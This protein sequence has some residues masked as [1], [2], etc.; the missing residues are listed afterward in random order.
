MK[1]YVTF[2]IAALLFA[3]SPMTAQDFHGEATYKT[4]RSIDIKMDSTKVTSDMEKQMIEML[5]KQFQKTFILSFNKE[6]SIY[7]E[8]VS[9]ESPKAGGMGI[10]FMGLGGGGSDI[11]YKNTKENR[12]VDQKDT[13][14]KI[15][16]VKDDME[17]VE[18][19]LESETKFIGEY[20]CFKATYTYEADV[21]TKA[22][23]ESATTMK[24]EDKD[25]EPE[26]EKV[27]KTVTAW[28]TPQI[29]VNN[30]PGTYHGLPGLILEISKD[31]QQIVC[32][33]I[34]LN[35]Q[36]FNKIEE[37]T[38]GKE[39]NQ[40]EYD[41]IMKKKRKEMMEQ[42]APRKG[43]SNTETISIRFGG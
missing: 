4:S 20:Q 7:K 37:P 39:V 41:E 27:T 13:M 42:F 9:L 8:D 31:K 21:M 38:K 29:P 12:F 3:T 1:T 43:E 10:S 18:W 33:K 35:P 19:K 22:S 15:F 34:V 32:T 16:L 23:L 14:G 24:G 5:K 26:F 17:K 11:L 25:K 2:L 40:A 30:G 36:N 28:Y 6:A